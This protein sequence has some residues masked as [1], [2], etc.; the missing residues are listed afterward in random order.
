[1]NSSQE[2]LPESF[3]EFVGEGQEECRNCYDVVDSRYIV[4]GVC[5]GCR[6]RIRADGGQVVEREHTAVIQD[7]GDGDLLVDVTRS[8]GDADVEGGCN[9]RHLPDGAT[10]IACQ[11]RGR[12]D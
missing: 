6:N 11:E 4:N 2:R 10:C 9:C 1:M 12:D 3:G 7:G 8:H 5:V